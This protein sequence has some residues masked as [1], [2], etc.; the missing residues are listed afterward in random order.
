MKR[1]RRCLLWHGRLESRMYERPK[2]RVTRRWQHGG[3]GD[4]LWHGTR[5]KLLLHHRKL[6]VDLLRDRL[7]WRWGHA[8]QEPRLLHLLLHKRLLLLRGGLLWHQRLVLLLLLHGR[9]LLRHGRLRLLR[10]R[11]LLLPRQRRWWW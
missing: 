10:R 4:L 9:L 1:T 2:S 7:R 6:A 3:I 8:R 11:P 5:Q